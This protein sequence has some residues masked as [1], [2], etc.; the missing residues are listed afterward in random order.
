[1]PMPS[2]LGLTYLLAQAHIDKHV[3]LGMP[4]SRSFHSL[5]ADSGQ[6]DG[7]DDDLMMM[8]RRMMNDDDV[9]DDRD[10]DF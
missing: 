8:M 1:M 9:N 5:A 7:D 10:N 3:N 4:E 2:D 6:Y